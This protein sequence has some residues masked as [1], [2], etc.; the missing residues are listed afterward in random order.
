[1]LKYGKPENAEITRKPHFT[2]DDIQATWSY[3]SDGTANDSPVKLPETSHELKNAALTVFN[4]GVLLYVLKEAVLANA[5]LAFLMI[6]S[7]AVAVFI[8]LSVGQR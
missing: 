5:P 8:S 3:P 2:M 1:M 7:P 4:S 6:L